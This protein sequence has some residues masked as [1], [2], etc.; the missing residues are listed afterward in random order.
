[1]VG[2]ERGRRL[3]PAP[4]LLMP[5]TRPKDDHEDHDHYGNQG[6][7]SHVMAHWLPSSRKAPQQKPGPMGDEPGFSHRDQTLLRQPMK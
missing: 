7:V 2:F 5:A 1:M 6:H 4:L 3:R